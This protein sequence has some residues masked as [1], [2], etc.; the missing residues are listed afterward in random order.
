MAALELPTR[1]RI[2]VVA[3]RRLGDVLL[4]TPLIRSLKRGY[5]G[6]VIDALVFSGTEGILA[7]N[8]DVSG[9]VTMPTS[10]TTAQ[11][12]SLLARLWRRYDLA[13]STQTGDR[14]AFFAFI[15][16]MRRA[17]LVEP[18]G[19]AAH[20][21]RVSFH[22]AVT[23]SRG[24]HRVDEMLRIADAL[25][26]PRISE[27]AAPTGTLRPEHRFA[28]PYAVIHAVPMFRYKRWTFEGWRAL[29]ESLARRGITVI[30]TGGPSPADGEYL[31]TV[32]KGMD[33]RR[34]D[35]VLAWPELAAAVSAA[36]VYI[37][38]DTSVTHLAAATGCP[39]IAIYGPTD[40]RIWGPWPKD[41]LQ[42]PWDAAGTLQ[43]RGNIW[44]VQNPLPCMPC[45]LEG[46]ERRVD[47]H[48]CCLDEL[49]ATRVIAAVDQ[50]LALAG[51]A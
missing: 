44:I 20:L 27:V 45:Q 36:A 9:V 19:V 28:Q 35:G 50:A 22:R 30:A 37:G 17:G 40:P 32:W 38:P 48:S 8:A 46:C 51:R 1:P 2:L 23:V 47:S 11:T 39:T 18:N 12:L 26:I 42:E 10:A 13:I 16:G 24:G 25:G 33:I 34:L 49:P 41:G 31:D 15:S 7:G 21:K 4:T 14:P 43:R 3:L 29:A 5:P 6:A